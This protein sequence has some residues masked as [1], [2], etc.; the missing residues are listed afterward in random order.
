MV[1]DLIGIREFRIRNYLVC[2]AGCYSLLYCIMDGLE[3][4]V[5]KR[6]HL[7]TEWLFPMIWGS[8]KLVAP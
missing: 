6:A 7:P 8:S 4:S 1:I 2:F 5:A 3:S